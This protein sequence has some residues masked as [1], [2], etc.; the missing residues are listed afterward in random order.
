MADMKKAPEPENHHSKNWL[1]ENHGRMLSLKRTSWVSEW[2]S[3]VLPQAAYQTQ[4]R[5]TATTQ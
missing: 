3:S 4:G 1:R 5:K 2:S